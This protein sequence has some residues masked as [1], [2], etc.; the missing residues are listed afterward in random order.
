MGELSDLSNAFLASGVPIFI[1]ALVLWFCV[2]EYVFAIR[3]L[4]V[5]FAAYNHALG[6]ASR[7]FTSATTSVV[8][9]T[10]DA[11]SAPAAG[12]VD[13]EEVKVTALPS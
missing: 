6:G 11:S 3:W 8:M 10:G 12:A 1:V 9:V 13:T 4:S 7:T 5:P 2:L